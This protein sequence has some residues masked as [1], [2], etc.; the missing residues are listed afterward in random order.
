MLECLRKFVL[1]ASCKK[2]KFFI[3][4]VEYL[5]FIITTAG[6]TIDKSRVAIIN[7]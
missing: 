6:V 5:S 4:E 2:C 3:I 7:K 1:F